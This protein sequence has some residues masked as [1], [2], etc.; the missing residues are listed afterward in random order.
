M[1]SNRIIIDDSKKYRV[2]GVAIIIALGLYLSS[3]TKD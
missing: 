2:L 1:D 3:V